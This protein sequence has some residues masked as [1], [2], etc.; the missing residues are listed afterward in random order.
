MP[1]R[2]VSFLKTICHHL[3]LLIYLLI[4]VKCC[5]RETL[6]EMGKM[7][8]QAVLA[9][10]YV[11]MYISIFI[12]VFS[13]IACGVNIP[14]LFCGVLLEIKIMLLLGVYCSNVQTSLFSIVL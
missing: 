14:S 9:S 12:K 2:S 6:A 1:G 3:C 11:E 13:S 5:H 10:R 4:T 7:D 8:Y